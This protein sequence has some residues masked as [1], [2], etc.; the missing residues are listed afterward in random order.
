MECDG[1]YHV[2]FPRQYGRFSCLPPYHHLRWSS[3]KDGHKTGHIKTIPSDFDA[4]G[5]N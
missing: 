4:S 3:T 2:D 1:C 5:A